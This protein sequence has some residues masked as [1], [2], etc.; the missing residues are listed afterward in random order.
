[1][2]LENIEIFIQN[3]SHDGEELDILKKKLNKNSDLF[4]SFD[5]K[6]IISNKGKNKIQGLKDTDHVFKKIYQTLKC[7][8]CKNQASYEINDQNLCWK[9]SYFILSQV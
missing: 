5:Y 7:A 9:H 6:K 4:N 1:M 8:K 2:L 3:R